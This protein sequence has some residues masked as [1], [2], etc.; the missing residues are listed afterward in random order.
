MPARII[1]VANQKGGSGKTTIAMGLAGTLGRRGHKVLVVDADQQATAT[2]WAK[3]APDDNPFP[4]NVSG[5]S[6]AGDKVHREV[7][8][9]LGDYDFIVVDCPPAVDSAVPASALMIADLAL[10][11]IIP[12]P[13]DIWA[14]RGI[15]TLIEN[16]RDTVNEGIQA[17]LVPNMCQPNTQITRQALE[18]LDGFAIARTAASL[19]L[20]TAHRQAAALGGTVHDFDGAGSAAQEL[21]TLTDEVLALLGIALKEVRH[22]KAANG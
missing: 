20:R 19:H 3:A 12:S 6:A 21:N 13:P 5:L 10:V 9:Y 14:A 15:R 1:V 7:K 2:Q 17:R 22:V 16:V 8:K 11:P 4:A 18:L